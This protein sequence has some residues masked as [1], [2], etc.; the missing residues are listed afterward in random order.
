MNKKTPYCDIEVEKKKFHSSKKP[1]IID[2]VNINKILTSD[3]FGYDKNKKTDAKL[4]IRYQD[5][6]KIRLL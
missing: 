4:F 1:I 5:S 2:D 6:K 3:R